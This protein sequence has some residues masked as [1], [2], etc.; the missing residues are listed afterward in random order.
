MTSAETPQILDATNRPVWARRVSDFL[1]A[2]TWTDAGER[3]LLSALAPRIR[4]RRL[5]DVGVGAGRTAWLLPLLSDDYTAIDYTAEMVT[6]AKRAHPDLDIR[7]GDARALRDFADASFDFV[8]FSNNGLDALAHSDRQAALREFHRVLAPG[9][10]LMYSTLDRTGRDF[11]ARP[12]RR[13]DRSGRF[14]RPHR[15]LAF[16]AR[17]PLHLPRYARETANWLTVR[18][19]AEDHGTWAIAP[20]AALEFQLLVHYTTPDGARAEVE[21]AGFRMES[22]T[23]DRGAAIV[24]AT[25][26]RADHGFFHVVAVKP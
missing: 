8:M 23:D 16:T 11:S 25:T 13:F 26:H 6:A 7:L 18:R 9:G 12:W 10:I 4:G 20:L 15:A 1:A 14:S 24:A 21:D 3:N 17:L 19:R 22:M 5:L 2:D